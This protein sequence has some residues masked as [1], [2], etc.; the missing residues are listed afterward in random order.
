MFE[1]VADIDV[2]HV[3]VYVIGILTTACVPSRLDLKNMTASGIWASLLLV[4]WAWSSRTKLAAPPAKLTP[5]HGKNADRIAPR[6]MSVPMIVKQPTKHS[7]IV[8]RCKK[9]SCKRN[10]ARNI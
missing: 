2:G 10:S 1:Y 7:P 9:N 3:V 6:N 5:S 8:K 4:C